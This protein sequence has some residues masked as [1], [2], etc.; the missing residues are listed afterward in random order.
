MMRLS[1]ICIRK[2]K[3]LNRTLQAKD[4]MEKPNLDNNKKSNIG[5][6]NNLKLC[7]SPDYLSQ[8]QKKCNFGMIRLLDPPIFLSQL[9]VQK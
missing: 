9:P 2:E 5:Y 8:L 3:L 1:W 4:V 7:T 6:I